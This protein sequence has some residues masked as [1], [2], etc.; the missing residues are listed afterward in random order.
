MLLG[1]E[2]A[3]LLE[4]NASI[5]NTEEFVN[6]DSVSSTASRPTTPKNPEFHLTADQRNILQYQL[7]AVGSLSLI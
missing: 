4:D 1:R 5:G 7:S 6:P 3:L 2:L